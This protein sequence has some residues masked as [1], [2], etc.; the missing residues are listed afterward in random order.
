MATPTSAGID[1]STLSGTWTGTDTLTVAG[2][3]LLSNQLDPRR[4]S[5]PVHMTWEVDPEG[6]ATITLPDWPGVHPY[7]FKGV[8]GS[9]LSVD[10]SL[11]SSSLCSG[12]AHA[13][14]ARHVGVIQIDG[15]RLT[16]VTEAIEAWCPPSCLFSRRY[17][18]S[19]P[20]PAQ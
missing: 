20:L 13:Y 6:Q 17:D 12:N 15:K 1:L 9:D 2:S 7:T 16:L 10:L 18:I 14:S 5:S 11:S 3:C 19:R 4:V 8:I